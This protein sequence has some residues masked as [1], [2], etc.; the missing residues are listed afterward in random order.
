MRLKKSGGPAHI[1]FCA[2]ELIRISLPIQCVEAVFIACHL[3]A[4]MTAIK[5]VPLSFKSVFRYCMNFNL[6]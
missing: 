4:E 6:L 2:K 5:R 3:T 1:E